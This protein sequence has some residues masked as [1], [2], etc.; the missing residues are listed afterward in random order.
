MLQGLAHFAAKAYCPASRHHLYL[1]FAVND[2]DAKL[3]QPLVIIRIMFSQAEGAV[4]FD[5]PRA[6]KMLDVDASAA[7]AK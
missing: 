7:V 6:V 5:H 2:F 1:I 3:H 4:L